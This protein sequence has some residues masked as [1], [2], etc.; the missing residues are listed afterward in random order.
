M[1]E[2][3]REDV[4]ARGIETVHLG[5][6]LPSKVDGALLEVVA[7]GPVAE[8]LEEGVVVDVLADIVEIVVL[9]SGTNAL[10]RVARSLQ[11]GKRT[12]GVDLGVRGD[13]EQNLS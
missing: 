5:E 12:G 8:H 3:R 11:L 7:E 2:W 9:A 6:K 4:H 10:L 1:T 13:F